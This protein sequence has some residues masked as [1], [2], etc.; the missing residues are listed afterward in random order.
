MNIKVASLV[1]ITLLTTYAIYYL[2]NQVISNMVW[3]Q[4]QS[5]RQSIK[6]Y[7]RGSQNVP[8]GL[9]WKTETVEITINDERYNIKDQILNMS[10]QIPISWELKTNSQLFSGSQFLVK[11][12]VEYEISSPDQIAVLKI[13]LRCTG[14]SLNY[15]DWP[16]DAVIV[17]ELEKLSYIIRTLD[18]E[19]NV[20]NYINGQSV[21]P[22]SKFTYIEE[23]PASVYK[24]LIFKKPATERLIVPIDELSFQYSGPNSEKE[25]YLS[26][27]DQIVASIEI[28]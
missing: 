25:Q 15:S 24:P 4:F 28:H 18:I 5:S 1:L 10:I 12:C 20:F 22:A 7:P 19:K 6:N 17:T 2:N 26:I 11:D 9:D 27:A 3:G 23:F 8:K 21:E 14:W 16:K 13:Q